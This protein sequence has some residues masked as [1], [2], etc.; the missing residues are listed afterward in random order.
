MQLGAIHGMHLKLEDWYRKY[1]PIYK[2][3][4][5]RAPVVVVTG[6]HG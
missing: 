4:L 2:F 3:F 5:G 6:Q 1:G